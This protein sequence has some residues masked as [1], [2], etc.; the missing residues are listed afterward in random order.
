MTVWPSAAPFTPVTLAKISQR[1]R[2]L[3]ELAM[4]MT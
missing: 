2:A 1:S 3:Q 4:A